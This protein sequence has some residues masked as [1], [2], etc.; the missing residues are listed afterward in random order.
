VI[1]SILPESFMTDR[2]TVSR[3]VGGLHPE[4]DLK[5]RSYTVTINGACY[6]Q[7]YYTLFL[8]G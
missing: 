4:Q 6:Q 7:A 3:V 2:L 1:V 8:N 5:H